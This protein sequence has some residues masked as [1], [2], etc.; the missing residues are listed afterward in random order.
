MN[1]NQQLLSWL[2]PIGALLA[3][4]LLVGFTRWRILVSAATVAVVATLSVVLLDPSPGINIE[5]GN[6]IVALLFALGG[7]ALGSRFQRRTVK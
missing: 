7:G 3:G 2:L 5:L 4:M 1:A 6:T